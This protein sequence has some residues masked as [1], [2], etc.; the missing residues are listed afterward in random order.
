MANAAPYSVVSRFFAELK[1]A[2]S[3][4]SLALCT[5]TVLFVLSQ[6]RLNM[7]MDR[8]S[9]GQYSVSLN[10]GI[11]QRGRSAD[12]FTLIRKVHTDSHQVITGQFKLYFFMT[13]NARYFCK[14]LLQGL[15][16]PSL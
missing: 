15:A 11:T 5:S 14:D 4:P 16:K 8:D 2:P 7:D 10:P 9:L 3:N 13:K 12:N 6:D 1:D